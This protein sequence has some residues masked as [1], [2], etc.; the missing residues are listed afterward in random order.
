[1]TETSP[2]WVPDVDANVCMH[3]RKSEFSVINRRV[4]KAVMRSVKMK[5]VCVYEFAAKM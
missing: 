2:V 4:R 1:M 3:C 5:R